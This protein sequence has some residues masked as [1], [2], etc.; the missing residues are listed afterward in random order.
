MEYT[1]VGGLFTLSEEPQVLKKNLEL[2]WLGGV[3]VP[4]IKKWDL[5]SGFRSGSSSS[6]LKKKKKEISFRFQFSKSDTIPVQSG[7]SK[8]ISTPKL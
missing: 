2:S 1:R 8:S 3:P 7:L 6:P 4:H 5:E